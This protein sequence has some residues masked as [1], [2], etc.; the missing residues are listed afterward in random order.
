MNKIAT[1][2]L[3]W[4]SQRHPSKSNEY[5]REVA[6]KH[7]DKYGREVIEKAMNH[8][9]CTSLANFVNLCKHYLEKSS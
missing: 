2:Y 1:R 7:W 6:R 3:K 5:H 9:S 8:S 4:I